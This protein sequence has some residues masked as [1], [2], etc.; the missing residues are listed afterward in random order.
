MV[1]LCEIKAMMRQKTAKKFCTPA[2]EQ[3]LKADSKCLSDDCTNLVHAVKY[4][5]DNHKK[6]KWSFLF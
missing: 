5:S 6:I 4:V 1:A 3:R 2:L